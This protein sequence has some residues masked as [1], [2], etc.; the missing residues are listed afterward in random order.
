[1]NTNW[2]INLKIAKPTCHSSEVL[3]MVCTIKNKPEMMHSEPLGFAFEVTH[4]CLK[5][6]SY[7]SA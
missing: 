3:V 6:V 2:A 7:V 5:I 4:W 1:M